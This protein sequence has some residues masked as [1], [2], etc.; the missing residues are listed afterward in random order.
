MSNETVC[1]HQSRYN[2]STKN[3]YTVLVNI[4]K[5]CKLGR[6]RQM[7]NARTISSD[8]FET[9]SSLKLLDAVTSMNFKV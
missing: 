6:I 7:A 1:K 5:K 4:N 3:K 2:P 9:Q 8:F